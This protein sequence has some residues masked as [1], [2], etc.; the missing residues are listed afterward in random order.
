MSYSCV[1]SVVLILIRVGPILRNACG[2][3]FVL[4]SYR[5]I[6]INVYPWPNG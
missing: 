5:I 1:V 2:I 4:H 6:T 3:T